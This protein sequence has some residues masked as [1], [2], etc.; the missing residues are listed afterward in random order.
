MTERK[1]Y[2]HRLECWRKWLRR[3][4]TFYFFRIGLHARY[5]TSS[6]FRMRRSSM[7]QSPEVVQRT[8]PIMIITFMSIGAGS[9]PAE[10]LQLL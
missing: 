10:A 1:I 5:F 6:F 9:C 4:G 2:E 7:K 3:S 8:Q